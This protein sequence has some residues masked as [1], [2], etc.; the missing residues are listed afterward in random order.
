MTATTAM[1]ETATLTA[2]AMAMTTVMAMATTTAMML[3][4]PPTARMLMMTMAA[5]K[6]SD[7][8]T[9]IGQQ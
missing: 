1:V 2:M 5:F 9:G 8:M 4:L 6:I 3:P 7:W